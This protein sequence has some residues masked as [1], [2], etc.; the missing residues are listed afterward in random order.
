[1]VRKEKFG[2]AITLSEIVLISSFSSES[3]MF[4]LFPETCGEKFRH[5]L[6]EPLSL[7]L[8]STDFDVLM[9]SLKLFNFLSQFL[10]IRKLLPHNIRSRSTRLLFLMLNLFFFQ[11]H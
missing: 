4:A 6:D 3:Q 1:M 7:T 5:R 8:S 2:K 9:K 10:Q 11:R